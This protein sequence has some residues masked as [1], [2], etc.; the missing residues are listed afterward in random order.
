MDEGVPRSGLPWARSCA[1]P[2][3]L[4]WPRHRGARALTRGVTR[5]APAGVP[6]L[7][8][9]WGRIRPHPFSAGFDKAP[10]IRC[11]RPRRRGWGELRGLSG[12]SAQ[13]PPRSPHTERPLV[14]VE[15]PRSPSPEVAA[16]T[17]GPRNQIPRPG[18]AVPI[19]AAALVTAPGNRG[20]AEPP[21]LRRAPSLSPP[22][23]PFWDP[24]P[25]VEELPERLFARA[26][27]C[28][29]LYPRFQT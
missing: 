5:L 23:T 10:G 19:I 14:P 29:A 26:G 4:S 18:T 2:W 21:K 6:H 16:A 8:A 24:S 3:L 22:P 1:R 27:W 25:P 15:Q 20:G 13:P 11:P 28:R 17:A 12:G 9:P 7:S